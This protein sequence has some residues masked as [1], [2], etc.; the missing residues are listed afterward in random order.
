MGLGIA[1]Q[2]LGS[3]WVRLRAGDLGLRG[4]P[5]A[6]SR[7]GA[8]GSCFNSASGGEGR[9]GVEW[10]EETLGSPAGEDLERLQTIV[11]S[12]QAFSAGRGGLELPSPSPHIWWAGPTA[13]GRSSCGLGSAS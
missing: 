13:A 8:S 4:L 12:G 2:H 1:T 10:A 7:E 3:I 5:E 9:K 6:R 11:S